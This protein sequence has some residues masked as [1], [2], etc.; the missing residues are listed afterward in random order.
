MSKVFFEKYMFLACKSHKNNYYL[1]AILFLST[2][3]MLPIPN[4]TEIISRELGFK[5]FQ[6]DLILELTAEGA[7]VPFIARYRK[8]RTGNL[9]EN[10][11]RD[12]IELHTKQEN[13]Y[14]AKQ[15]AINGIEEMGKMTEELMQNIINAKTLKEVEEIY[16]PYRLKKKTKAMVAIEKGFQIVADTIKMNT[17]RISEDLLAKYP[18]E[19]IIT[20]AIDII[21]AEVSANATL[22]HA[23]IDA[24]K[25]SG[26]MVSTKKSDKM[27]EKLNEK[28]R[29]QI[30]KFEIYFAFDIALS[31]IK[32]YQ[33][34]ALNRGENIGILT[35]KIEKDEL[36]FE[37]MK[38]EY[39][40]FLEL[41]GSFIP[42][43]LAGFELGY[44]ALFGSVENELRSELSEV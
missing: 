26:R 1:A 41:R 33:I 17:L 11:I 2:T 34:L 44:E 8:E 14:K 5:A 39:S 4:Y 28:D 10:Q 7:T 12:I 25:K 6:I 20:G 9:D 3:K 24:L 19:E 21:G 32:P 18:K 15:T 42:E 36:I 43:L 16:K 13:L 30:K 37:M 40:R 27:L 35:V 29:D 23:L 22:R 38:T 31:R